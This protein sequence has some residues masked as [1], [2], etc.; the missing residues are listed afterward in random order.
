MYL[1]NKY[2]TWYNSIINNAKSRQSLTGYVEKHH[3]IPKSLGGSNNKTNIVRLTAREHFI[4][5]WL[6]PKMTT[7]QN[8]IKMIRA[9]WRMS[10]PGGADQDRYKINSSLY[11]SVRQRYAQINSLRHKGKTMSSEATRKRHATMMERYG[12]MS[13][14]RITDEMRKAHSIRQTGKKHSEESK[15]KMS[16]SRQGS[17]NH[18]A[19]I[20]ED[21]ARYIK[22]SNESSLDL[23]KRFNISR[24]LVYHI[25]SGLSWTHISDQN[26]PGATPIQN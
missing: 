20:T 5:H 6:L 8:R 22:Y 25:K 2:T 26:I 16:E 7:D 17:K 18:S 4:C 12:V 9:L 10:V 11:E 23:A 15:Q 21:Q 24:S 13:K 3:I 19:K 14:T 1:P